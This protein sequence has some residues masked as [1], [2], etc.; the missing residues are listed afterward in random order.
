MTIQANEQIFPLVRHAGDR[1]FAFARIR[2]AEKDRCQS[3]IRQTELIG[4]LLCNAAQLPW[5]IHGTIG[6]GG[7]DDAKK[8]KARQNDEIERR[9][10]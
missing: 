8:G 10:F 6:H 7:M 9:Y 2:Q 3:Q 1:L 5:Q 4:N